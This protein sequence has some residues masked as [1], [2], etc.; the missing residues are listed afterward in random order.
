VDDLSNWYIR[1]S[2][3][4]FWDGEEDAVRT[5]WY[6]VVQA[7]RVIAPVMPFLAEW[8]WGRVVASVCEEAP[9]SV[10]LAGWPSVVEELR[11]EPL[12]TE[13]GEV[14]ELVELGHQVRA[15][16]GVRLRQPL[17]RAWVHGA[18]AAAKHEDLIRDE[19]RVKE[20]VLVDEPLAQFRY[21]PNLP[22]VGKKLGRD[23]PKVKE[24]LEAGAFERVDGGGGVRVAGY[25]LSPDELLIE[26]E[27]EPGTA[28]SLTY[29]VKLDLEVDDELATE[30]RVLDLIHAVNSLRRERGLELTDRIAVTLPAADADLL[31]RHADWIKE[32]TLAVRIEANGS[33]LTIDKVS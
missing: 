10:F 3:R 22:V 2:R 27:Q 19:L 20:V 24:A 16:Q 21:R 14:R 23:V 7:L 12:L 4:R 31:S 32:E 6:G 8:A 26:R 30:G 25:E 17:R 29:S 28:H 11:D 5:L 1:R 13:I 15:E 18:D 33:E 9:E